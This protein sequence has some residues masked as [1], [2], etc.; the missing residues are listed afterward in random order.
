MAR[1]P[2]LT[3]GAWRSLRALILE[4]DG[5]ACQIRGPK[6]KGM[7]TEV[8]HI[9][10]PLEG[11]SFWDPNNLRSSCKRCNVVSGQQ[12]RVRRQSLDLPLRL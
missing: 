4:Q 1:D 2:R 6:C 7:A 8:D 12:V 5:Y 3:S 9:V 10:S 11:G